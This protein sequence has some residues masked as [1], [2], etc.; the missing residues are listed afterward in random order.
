MLVGSGRRPDL[1]QFEAYDPLLR[2]QMGMSD[3]Q[4]KLAAAR[5]D[6]INALLQGRQ[7]SPFFD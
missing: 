3:F 6:R 7:F 2:Q 4:K 5:Q 1:A